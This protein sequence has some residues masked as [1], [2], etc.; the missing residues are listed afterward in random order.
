[1]TQLPA[2]HLSTAVSQM[3]QDIVQNLPRRSGT[4]SLLV[5]LL[6]RRNAFAVWLYR[7]NFARRGRLRADGGR[8]LTC[9]AHYQGDRS[10]DRPYHGH[11]LRL[12]AWRARTITRRPRGSPWLISQ[13]I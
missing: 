10:K 6:A 3:W 13:S 9:P 11:D 8:A 12:H 2:Y 1:M 7:E 4:W 5:C